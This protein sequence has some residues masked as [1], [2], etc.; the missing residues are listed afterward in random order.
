[1]EDSE[2]RM[3]TQ[4][5]R[6]K[7]NAK[8]KNLAKKRMNRSTDNAFDRLY[9]ND[10]EKR[11]EKKEFMEKLNASKYKKPQKPIK[12]KP[13]RTVNRSI[14]VSDYSDFMNNDEIG[15]MI[16]RRVMRKKYYY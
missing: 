13:I 6:P 10:V 7:L 16:R 4:M 15:E 11:R 8:S 14:E 2:R 1:M 9:K 3:E 12:K 5:F